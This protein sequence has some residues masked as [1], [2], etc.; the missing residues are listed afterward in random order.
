[1]RWSPYSF[2]CL[3]YRLGRTWYMTLISLA[4]CNL[5]GKFPTHWCWEEHSRKLYKIISELHCDWSIL[6]L[7]FF[8]LGQTTIHFCKQAPEIKPYNDLQSNSG[9]NN[10][11]NPSFSMLPP[12]NWQRSIGKFY[13]SVP[14]PLLEGPPI[15]IKNIHLLKRQTLLDCPLSLEGLPLTI[16]II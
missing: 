10:P 14:R 13:T 16:S 15:N 9:P 11:I 3:M 1:M 4:R 5:N 6:K 2:V 12:L 8:A 7:N